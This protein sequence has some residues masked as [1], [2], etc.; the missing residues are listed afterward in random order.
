MKSLP[1]VT[2]EQI[3]ADAKLSAAMCNVSRSTWLA[4][5]SAGLNPRPNRVIGR[6]LWSI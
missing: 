2:R 4:W 5:D 1:E 6:V 3:M